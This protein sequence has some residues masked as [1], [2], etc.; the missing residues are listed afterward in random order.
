MVQCFNP[1]TTSLSVSCQERSREVERAREEAKSSREEA[2]RTAR[3]FDM[4]AVVA[5]YYIQR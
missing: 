5:G 1:V 4:M 2:S 3:G